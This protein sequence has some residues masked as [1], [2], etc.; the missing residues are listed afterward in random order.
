[1]QYFV[2]PRDAI[3]AY[4]EWKERRMSYY[5]NLGFKKEKLRWKKHDNLVFYAKDAWDIEYEFPFGWGELE[6]VHYRGD[7]D[8]TQHQKFSGVDMSVVDEKTKSSYI[9]HV[10]ETSVGVDRT[11]LALLSEAYSEDEMNGERRVFL[12]FPPK[13]APVKVAVFPLL[14]NKPDLVNKAK[15]IYFDLKKHFINKGLVKFD[16]NGNIGKRYRRQ[17]EIGTPYCVTVDFETLEKGDVTIRYRDTGRQ[18]RIKI[19]DI[20]EYVEKANC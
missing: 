2:H 20:K 3:S 10:V 7:Y 14:R 9:P 5:I 11:F 4:E 1:M 13:L 15:E 12:K 18:E 19:E 6:G 8:L 17:D 16:D